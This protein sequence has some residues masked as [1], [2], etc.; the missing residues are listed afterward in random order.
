[1]KLI[2]KKTLIDGCEIELY[3]SVY[4]SEN[5]VECITKIAGLSYNKESVNNPEKLFEYLKSESAGKSSSVM[6]FAW[7]PI[8]TYVEEDCFKKV[9]NHSIVKWFEY[10][11]DNNGV[12]SGLANLRTIF[13]CN[14]GSL[15]EAK[16]SVFMSF[17]DYIR[18]NIF[19]FKLKI[20]LW[21]FAQVVRHREAS[22]MS[23]S[24]RR[25]KDVDSYEFYQSDRSV[26]ISIEKSLWIP[27]E[28][29][30][31]K[32]LFDSDDI[33]DLL[34]IMFIEK[35]KAGEPLEVASRIFPQ[36]LFAN[37]YV[38]YTNT[39]ESWENFINLRAEPGKELCKT[40]TQL[41]TCRVARAMYQLV[42]E[43]IL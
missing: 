43:N 9:L 14:I 39:E 3:D 38:Q 28:K 17:K 4:I 23:I 32:Y 2:D 27:E 7:Y 8:D 30:S 31:I 5:P 34:K 20:P 42:E 25:V 21:M 10:Y 6:E 13:N 41:E 12:I 1:M 40:H 29:K 35:L 37:I 24:R 16:E 15:E 33:I 26:N 11:D 36:N 19:T 18:D 22:Y